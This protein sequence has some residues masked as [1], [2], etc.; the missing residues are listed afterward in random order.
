MIDSI[1][2]VS[3]DLAA[4]QAATPAQ[5]STTVYDVARFQRLHQQAGAAEG[6]QA[7]GKSDGFASVLKTLQTLNGGV[8]GLG[9]E[10]AQFAANR[11]ELTPGDMI[12]LTVRCHQF[13]FQCELTANVA[14]R[15]SEGVQQLFR[16][17]S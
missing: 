8:E 4:A 14:N 10:A 9:T 15:S 16:Q 11:Q 17:Q 3:F 12:Q 13:M 2:A 5:A 6:T 7:V 1:A